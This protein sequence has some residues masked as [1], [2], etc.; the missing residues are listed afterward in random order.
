MGPVFDDET[1]KE[2]HEGLTALVRW[3]KV[4]DFPIV[5][6]GGISL[7]NATAVLATGVDS[8]AVYRDL[9]AGHDLSIRLEKWLR[10]F[11]RRGLPS[12]IDRSFDASV[13]PS[14]EEAPRIASSESTGE[15]AN[16]DLYR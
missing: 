3:R 4:L 2:A 1:H 6:A 5:A 8:I 14:T 10:L 13:T 9:S 15:K 16:L 7:E 12:G 11:E